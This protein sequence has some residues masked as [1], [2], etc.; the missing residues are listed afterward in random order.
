MLAFCC[1]QKRETFAMLLLSPHFIRR[2]WFFFFTRTIN[3]KLLAAIKMKV[4]SW[5]FFLLLLR[6]SVMRHDVLEALFGHADKKKERSFADEE[7]PPVHLF[8]L[9]GRFR[10]QNLT[11]DLLGLWV[12][13]RENCKIT[14]CAA[15]QSKTISSTEC[16]IIGD[17]DKS[18][19]NLAQSISQDF[20][21][22]FDLGQLGRKTSKKLESR[23]NKS[24]YSYAK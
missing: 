4:F 8:T 5:F 10:L 19:I 20:W 18:E 6:S 12:R 21:K 3:P 16:S 11:T 7:M 1:Y 2:C 23:I 15:R 17:D 13:R 22:L 14:C 9:T 24:I